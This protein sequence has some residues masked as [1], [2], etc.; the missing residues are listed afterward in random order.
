MVDLMPTIS[1]LAYA[2]A[3]AAVGL[4]VA[5]LSRAWLG[6][7]GRVP[8]YPE[9][10]WC[11][12]LPPLVVVMLPLLSAL[13]PHAAGPMASVH[14]LWHAWEEAAHTVPATHGA[15]HVANVLLLLFVAVR[16]ACAVHG[17][18]CRYAIAQALRATAQLHDVRYGDER[19]Y[20]LPSRDPA[21]FTV[22]L[23][24]PAVFLSSGLLEAL[25]P[26]E[27]EA[28]LAHESAHVRRRDGLMGALLSTFYT[29]FPLPGS[30]ILLTDWERAVER[31][32]DAEAARRLG[33]PCDVAAALVRVA[34]LAIQFRPSVPGVPG[35]AASGDD[36]PGRVEAL[37]SM[38]ST[39]EAAEDSPLILPAVLFL[40]SAGVV[41]ATGFWVRHAVDLFVRH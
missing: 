5:R 35:F 17:L 12:I 25:T 21:C 24:R 4:T 16:L 38:P 32:C 6:R 37:L 34:R 11:V 7:R 40:L 27:C 22:G 1:L 2:Y 13:Q 10:V 41:S 39:G 33:N 14:T 26:R 15:L 19:I 23:V 18:A 20:R 36:I 31:A 29:I 9:A 3:A 8:S 30:R 28:V